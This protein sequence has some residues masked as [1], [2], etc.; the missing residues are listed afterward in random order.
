MTLALYFY[1]NV[2]AIFKYYSGG[3]NHLI[4]LLECYICKEKK[5]LS[6]CVKTKQVT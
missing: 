6:L 2:S 3:F 1:V 5:N 4:M